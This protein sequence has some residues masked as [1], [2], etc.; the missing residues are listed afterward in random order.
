M[1]HHFKQILSRENMTPT[2]FQA[3]SDVEDVK[4]TLIPTS[5]GRAEPGPRTVTVFYIVQFGKPDL[6]ETNA[7]RAAALAAEQTLARIWTSPGED[8]AWAHL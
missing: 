1:L 5:P 2:V 7:P 3:S 6:W 8:E 4:A